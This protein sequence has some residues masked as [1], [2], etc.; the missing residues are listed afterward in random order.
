MASC[1]DSTCSSFCWCLLSQ[2]RRY[3]LR[4]T[5]QHQEV[6]SCNTC[7][8]EQMFSTCLFMCCSCSLRSQWLK[9][10]QRWL[11]IWLAQVKLFLKATKPKKQR[12]ALLKMP[13]TQCQ[14]RRLLTQLRRVH[15]LQRV[16]FLLGHLLVE[17][18]ALER[19]L[20]IGLRVIKKP[21]N[22]TLKVVL[23]AMVTNQKVAQAEKPMKQ[24]KKKLKRPT[25]KNFRKKV[26]LLK[27][28]N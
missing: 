27:M 19:K 1:W 23:K 18:L 7:H 12:K 20:E 28:V 25:E 26:N 16:Q 5:L 24:L 17:Q 10:F 13:P 11:Q 3:S 8:L 15:L 22:R 6:I 21:V 4:K 9:H 2:C 14:G